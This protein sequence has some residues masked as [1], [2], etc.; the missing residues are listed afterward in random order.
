MSDPVKRIRSQ[1][2]HRWDLDGRPGDV[3]N[4]AIR[5]ALKEAAKV[6]DD[7]AKE[8]KEKAPLSPAIAQAEMH[9]AAI[10]AMIPSGNDPAPDGTG[11]AE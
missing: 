7:W 2:I 1:A 5:I 3:A 11:S 10:R 8:V 4:Y 9:A 6:I